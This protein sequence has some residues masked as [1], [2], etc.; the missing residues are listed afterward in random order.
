MCICFYACNTHTHT[1]T[2]LP[3]VLGLYQGLSPARVS[4]IPYGRSGL[5]YGRSG[6]VSRV[7]GLVLRLSP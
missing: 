2:H 1:H 3:G 5:V 6:L 7:W 4:V